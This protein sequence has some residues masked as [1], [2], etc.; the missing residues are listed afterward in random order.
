MRVNGGGAWMAECRTRRQLDNGAVQIPAAY[1][2]CNFSKGTEGRPPL[3]THSEVTTLFHEFGHGLHHLLT[4]ESSLRVS[5]ING[6]AWD[7][8]EL[9]SQLMEN[10]CWDKQSINL[11]SSH[12]ETAEPLPDAMLEKMLAA[13]NFQAGMKMMAQLEYALFDFEL[14]H[15]LDQIDADYVRQTITSVR[16]RTEVS[17]KPAFNRFENSFGH[18]FGG[19][20]AAGYYSYY[21]AE[22]L[23]ADVFSRFEQAG[24]FDD[25]TGK[26][27]LEKI[28]SRGGAVKALELFRNFMG[29]DPD[30]AALLNQKGILKGVEG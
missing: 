10:W 3:L 7:A 30:I 24:V 4:A 15:H 13:R 29:R 21:W 16:Q 28:L 14:H 8:V 1:L 19:G 17:P 12:Y 6:V 25:V 27:F 9:P 11:I 23:S 2:V 20:Y 26:S 18:I 22:V 5:G